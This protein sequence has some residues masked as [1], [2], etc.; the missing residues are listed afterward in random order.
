MIEVGVS[1]IQNSLLMEDDKLSAKVAWF[2]SDLHD[3]VTR[4]YY[5]TDS[6]WVI[7]NVDLY[8][9]SGIEYSFTYDQGRFYTDISG[10][11]YLDASTC[12]Q[13]SAERIRKDPYGDPNTPNCVDGGFTT[14]LANIT[15]PPKYSINTTLGVRL[16]D[17]R[18][19]DI[20]VRR[21]Y[22][23]GPTHK[24]NRSWH[25]SGMTGAQMTYLS[26]VTYD[27]YANYQF[28]PNAAVNLT[29]SNLTDEYYVDPMALS[30]M[31][32][33]GRTVTIDFTYK[34]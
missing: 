8:K 3:M 27:A 11:Y 22:N 1:T 30:L 24:L 20:G 7:E 21:I 5:P 14:S 25:T 13:K 16:L 12:D 31:P 15:N 17:D 9:T 33:P 34:F 19:L 23:S 32:A 2:K 29:V 4:G 18:N 10:N 28:T 6:S 26:T